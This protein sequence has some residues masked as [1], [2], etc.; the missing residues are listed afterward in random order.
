M[1]ICFDEE[2]LEK[3][4]AQRAGVWCKSGRKSFK[5]IASEQR[6]ERRGLHLPVGFAGFARYRETSGCIIMHQFGWYRECL[7]PIFGRRLFFYPDYQL[8][9]YDH[10]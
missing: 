5:G 9:V 2:R 3:H 8:E 1:Y 7:R 10:V 4:C 6:I